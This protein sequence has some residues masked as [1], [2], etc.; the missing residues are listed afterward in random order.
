[1]CR[2]FASFFDVVHHQ[3]ELIVVVAVLDF[4]IY[5]RVRHR[6]AEFAE[7]ARFTLPQFLDYNVANADNSNSFALQ[8]FSCRVPILKQEM[9]HAFATGQKRAASLNA[10]ARPS[11][12][13]AHA[14]E[15][16]GTMLEKNADIVH[17]ISCVFA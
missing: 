6:P 8:R 12:H 3:D 16:A 4:D 7:L 15:F 5:A 1:L 9:R 11:Q 13:L 17:E 2:D 10:D 14:S